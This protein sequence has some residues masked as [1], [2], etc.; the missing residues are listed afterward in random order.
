MNDTNQNKFINIE[1]LKARFLLNQLKSDRI[2]KQALPKK[3][4]CPKCNGLLKTVVIENK[5]PI[6]KCIDCKG[7]WLDY[8]ELHKL[9]YLDNIQL[10]NIE[11]EKPL[12]KEIKISDRIFF[13][14]PIKENC[15]CPRCKSFLRETYFKPDNSIWMDICD[16]CKGSFF[17]YLELTKAIHVLKGL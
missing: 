5:F 3:T 9:L 6:E 8:G 4:K 2:K 14:N 10:D 1:D 15:V 16:N 12:K 13:Y 11:S 17:D 7:I